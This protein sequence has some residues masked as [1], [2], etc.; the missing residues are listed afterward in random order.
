[1]AFE[2][3]LDTEACMGH[4]RCYALAADLFDAD[5]DGHGVILQP[6][7]PVELMAQAELAQASCPEKA[8]TLVEVPS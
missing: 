3:R 2:L 6:F 1:M 4:G 7:V 8:I 5:D